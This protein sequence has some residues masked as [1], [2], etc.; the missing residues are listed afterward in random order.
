MA[1]SDRERDH[2]FRMRVVQA[3]S[4]GWRQLL[5]F[6]SVTIVCVTV[7]FSIRELA[8]RRTFADLEFRAIADFKANHYLGV[9]LPWGLVGA[10]VTWA[11]LER[12]LRRRHVERISSEQ[13]ET[14]KLID[15]G[16]RS[17]GLSKK[18]QTSPEDE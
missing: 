16:R 7:Y 2:Q 6:L 3:V 15:P 17:S 13:S 12:I 1:R 4:I 10:A 14:H 11:K 18:G 9:Y 8:G 5:T